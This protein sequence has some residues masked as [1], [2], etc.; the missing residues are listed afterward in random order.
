MY[1]AVLLEKPQIQ[2]KLGWGRKVL[3]LFSSSQFLWM[4]VRVD[5]LCDTGAAVIFFLG[6]QA[7]NIF[8]QN[9]VSLK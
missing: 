9:V 3:L 4:V 2:K 5:S 7:Y 8:G 1:F 6:K